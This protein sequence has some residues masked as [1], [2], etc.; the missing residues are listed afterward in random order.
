MEDMDWDSLQYRFNDDKVTA[1]LEQVGAF[2][3][4]ATPSL[5]T[6]GPL[7]ESCCVL[8]LV[9]L[10]TGFLGRL[11]DGRQLPLACLSYASRHCEVV[12]AAGASL[13]APLMGASAAS[14]AIPVDMHDE[15]DD[16]VIEMTAVPAS[17]TAAAPA[18]VPA[19][20]PQHASGAS[21]LLSM[22]GGRS[23]RHY[24]RRGFA[25]DESIVFGAHPV[26]LVKPDSAEMAQLKR[27]IRDTL[28][29]LISEIN[30]ALGVAHFDRAKRQP[31]GLVQPIT[32]RA[33]T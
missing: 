20:R 24:G 16:D 17:L 10:R 25:R 2:V 13:M 15:V 5:L 9:M 23:K 14:S 32:V 33:T 8:Q 3:S 18:E 6:P 21:S 27:S 28:Q 29:P 22:L 1:I 4:H 26:A 12:P 7:W 11:L 19:Q 30:Q 31:F